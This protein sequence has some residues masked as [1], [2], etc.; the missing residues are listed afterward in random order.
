MQW[1][2]DA[3]AVF[4]FVGAFVASFVTEQVCGV[5]S[6]YCIVEWPETDEVLGQHH[7]EPGNDGLGDPALSVGS[8]EFAA[9]LAYLELSYRFTTLPVVATF[10]GITS[11]LF[12]AR[13][14]AIHHR[15]DVTGVALVAPA[16]FDAAVALDPVVGRRYAWQR[17]VLAVVP[18]VV[19]A[20]VHPTAPNWD[21]LWAITITYGTLAIGAYYVN[22]A[23]IDRI[24]VLGL[25]CLGVGI[26]FLFAADHK[27]WVCVTTQLTEF[28]Y[29]GHLLGAAGVTLLSRTHSHQ[30]YDLFG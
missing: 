3:A 26:V 20:V 17:L 12:H 30:K 24:V 4:L 11:F 9:A 29:Y 10:V 19:L 25:L 22:R 5:S 1:Q 21:P 23:E 7:C 28:H 16:V 15:L 14:T 13:N 6:E 18:I 27:E 2:R 8:L